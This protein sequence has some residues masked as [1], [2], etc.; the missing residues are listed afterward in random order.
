MAKGTRFTATHNG[1]TFHRTSK[2]MSYTHAV[3]VTTTTEGELANRMSD[4]ELAFPKSL[5]NR[6]ER[7]AD[8]LARSP[9]GGAGTYGW[10]QSLAN[11]QK[12]AD[13]ARSQY[14]STPGTVV[15]IVPAVA[16]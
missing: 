10:S 13:K 8:W 6:E 3:I 4:I 7:M 1:E 9:K 15:T 5:P 11:A 2:S 14:R 12:M 16:G